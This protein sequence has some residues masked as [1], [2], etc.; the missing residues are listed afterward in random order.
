MHKLLDHEENQRARYQ[1]FASVHR[2]LEN[3]K[4]ICM[5]HDHEYQS[6]K[7]TIGLLPHMIKGNWFGV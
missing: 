5:K 3:D 4:I 7:P 2:M 6:Q 1:I